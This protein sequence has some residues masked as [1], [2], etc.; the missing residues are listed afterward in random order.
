MNPVTPAP[1]DLTPDD[2][3]HL[4]AALALAEQARP[5]C[6][7]NPAVGCVIANRDRRVLAQ[8]HTQATGGPHAEAV[9]IQHAAAAG[10]SLQGA[11][12]YVTLEPCSHFGRTPP[13]ADA[14]VAAGVARVVVALADPHP[15]VAGAGLQRLRA[16]GVQVDLLP[17]DHPVARA[18]REIN[19]GFLSRVQ[20]RRPWVRLKVAASLDG[21]TALPDGRSQWITGPAARQDGQR[22]RA[23]AGAVLTGIGTVRADDPLLNVR[24]PAGARQ[25]LRVVA[26]SRLSLSPQARLLSTGDPVWL[27]TRADA[28]AAQADRAQALRSLGVEI[29][30]LSTVAAGGLDLHAL[31][32]DLAAHALVN[33]LHVEA[34]ATLNGALIAAGLVDEYLVYLA[35][36]LLGQGRGMWNLPPLAG[37]DQSIDLRWTDLA[38]VGDDLRI[39]AREAGRDE[40]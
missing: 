29:R 18:A 15:L 37:L 31:L 6:P 30:V 2:L 14:L 33:E 27:Y 16:A 3:A 21:L 20:R 7:P 12:A 32:A 35:P 34:G 9:A 26:D 39:L 40:F 24:E 8:G 11:T 19:L 28:L 38:P 10:V 25:P 1:G 17:V 36:R 22:H 5:I 13:C 4:Q 23:R